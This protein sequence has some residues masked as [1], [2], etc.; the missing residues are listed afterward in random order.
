MASS[1]EN[2]GLSAVS[3]TIGVDGVVMVLEVVAFSDPCTSPEDTDVRLEPV[4]DLP[5]EIDE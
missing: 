3:A 5:D 4:S 1:T 2:D